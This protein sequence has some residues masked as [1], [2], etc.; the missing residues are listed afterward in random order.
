M[1]RM[2]GLAGGRV[3]AAWRARSRA[4]TRESSSRR[5][6][7]LASTCAC[8]AKAGGCGVIK[9]KTGRQALRQQWRRAPS[10]PGTGPASWPRCQPRRARGGSPAHLLLLGREHSLGLRAGQLR[11]L[12]EHVPPLQPLVHARERPAGWMN[13]E[14][15][16]PVSERRRMG[17]T[18]RWAAAGS[19]RWRHRAQSPH[20]PHL[21]A[22]CASAPP[23][24]PSGPAAAAASPR[25]AGG[26]S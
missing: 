22:A 10:A 4:A 3:E 5:L 8:G 1:K 25:S 11:E 9:T 15:G 14:P 16:V 18:G 19:R 23:A 24:R 6:R 20:P 2:A 17:R 12:V 7:T 13:G 26:S 21:R